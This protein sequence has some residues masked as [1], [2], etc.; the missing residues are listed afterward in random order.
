VVARSV[1]D[2]FVAQRKLAVVGVSRKGRKFGNAAYRAL[3]EKGYQV[4]PV[5]PSA[6]TLE[7]DRCYASLREL[8]EAVGGVL[9]VVPPAQTEQVVRDAAAAGIP[10]LWLQQGAASPQAVHLARENGMKV[11]H[12]EC[13]LM[14]IEPVVSIHRFHRW[15]WRALGK[16]PR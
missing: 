11:V 10:R 15:L 5:H 14:F 16:L 9:V 12:G 4:F 8:P 13:I 7:G 1:V 3:R 2:D 6:P